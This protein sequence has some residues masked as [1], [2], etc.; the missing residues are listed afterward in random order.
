MSF[1]AP[2]QFTPPALA[3]TNRLRGAVAGILNRW[4]DVI[5]ETPERD[6]AAQLRRV[7]EHVLAWDWGRLKLSDVTNAA[8]LAFLPEFL[9]QAEF[10]PLRLFLLAE[11]RAS[12]NAGFLSA[13]MTVLIRSYAPGAAHTV[14]LCAALTAARPRLGAKW[15]QVL[16]AVP[17][18]LDPE[19]APAALAGHM[20]AMPQP[21]VG[22][23]QMG[24][25][26]PHAPG[27]MDHAHLAYLRL[28]GP[29]LHDRALIDRLLD[30]LRPEGQ[31][32]RM[33]GAAEAVEA[34]VSPWLR[35]NPA[36]DLIRH[37]TESLVSLFGDPRLNGGG[38]WGGVR[39]DH[40]DVVLRWLT[41]ENITFFLDV[42]SAVEDS[43]MWEP[44]RKF[45]LDLHRA[46]RIQAA[47]VAFSP[48]AARHARQIRQQKAGRSGLAFGVQEAGGTRSNTSLLVL[49][50]GN[51]IVIE[52]SHNYKV[53]LF[54]AGNTAAPQLFQPRYDCEAI[55]FIPGA[56]T[57]VHNGNWQDSVRYIIGA[58]S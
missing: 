26:Q 4:P 18:L 1:D 43:H 21:W 50:I 31:Q 38:V 55:R 11:T 32:T 41:G 57:V 5:V 56:E 45:W 8:P 47:W 6:R 7:L 15:Q 24:I 48:A 17:T 36:P 52:G 35:Y 16:A 22:L 33:S 13:M 51:C 2:F 49:R 42:V 37:L 14:A 34:L 12:D 3:A 53:H 19:A 28:I 29:Q 10:E 23:R 27:L 30:W 25:G 9:A 58:L 40:R 44:R 39:G 54:R 20:L 46:G